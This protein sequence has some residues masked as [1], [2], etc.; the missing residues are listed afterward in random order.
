MIAELQ[1]ASA[2]TPTGEP[3]YLLLALFLGLTVV[4]ILVDLW[5]G[6]RGNRRAHVPSAMATVASFLAAIYFAETVGGYWRFDPTYL[7]IHLVAA[8]SGTGL[9]LLT[10]GTGVLHLKNRIGRLW[11][12]RFALLFVLFVLLAT[13]TAFLM[14]QH[15]E[16]L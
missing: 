10:V 13:G 3:P 12:K 1:A 5:T 15:G 9:A 4:L 8:W 6:F 16:R 7:R 11:H 14:F 2:A